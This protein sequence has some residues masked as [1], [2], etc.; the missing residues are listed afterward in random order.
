M[1]PFF[2]SN[3]GGADPASALAG[4]RAAREACVLRTTL[5]AVARLTPVPL[6]RRGWLGCALAARPIGAMCAAFTRW[7]ARGPPRH[8]HRFFVDHVSGG[9]ADTR[10]KLSVRQ[11]EAQK[12]RKGADS[13]DCTE[14]F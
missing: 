4:A 6:K 8:C 14:A 11:F 12:N 10:V 9:A 5:V 7:A 2:T 1:T 3:R 13:D